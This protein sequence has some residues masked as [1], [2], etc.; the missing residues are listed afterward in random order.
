M[1]LFVV[2]PTV[3]TLIQQVTLQVV[4]ISTFMLLVDSMGG[5]AA[6]LSGVHNNNSELLTGGVIVFYPNTLYSGVDPTYGNFESYDTMGS[7]TRKLPKSF[8]EILVTTYLGGKSPKAFYNSSDDETRAK[9]FPLL[10][11]TDTLKKKL[12]RKKLFFVTCE[13]DVLRDEGKA[14]ID[15]LKSIDDIQV[16]SHHYD[17]EHG[18]M[19]TNG[20]GDK[21]EDCLNKIKDW[22]MK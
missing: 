4:R 18:F 10:L 21:F 7:V 11:D 22:M 8:L 15:K 5:T 20:R 17:E 12:S 3:A 1:I 2:P 14:M 9:A 13:Y 6:I 16:E 19:C